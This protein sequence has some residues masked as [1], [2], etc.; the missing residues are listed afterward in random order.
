MVKI[1]INSIIAPRIA[2]ISDDAFP[3]L[4]KI[5]V[6]LLIEILILKTIVSMIVR[7]IANPKLSQAKPFSTV[8]KTNRERL[9]LSAPKK[10]YLP[11]VLLPVE[12][13]P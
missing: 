4:K 12:S 9:K 13:C 6:L 3:L 8:R 2:D 1:L 5:A 10:K 11:T 7:I